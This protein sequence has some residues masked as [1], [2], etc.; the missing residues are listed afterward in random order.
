P[1]P[2]GVRS[3]YAP[4]LVAFVGG[5]GWAAGVGGPVGWFPLGPGEIYNPWYHASRRYYSNLNLGGLRGYRGHDRSTIARS[6][7]NHYN[8]YRNGSPPRGEHYA[9]RDAPRGFTAIPG[10]SFAGGQH[11]QRDLLHIDRHQLAT[12]SVLPRGT[13]LR[14]AAGSLAPVRGAHARALP[15]NGFNREVVARHAPPVQSS[16]RR[17]D[18]TTRVAGAQ[19]ASTYGASVRVLNAAGPAD[20]AGS[21]RVGNPRGAAGNSRWPFGTPGSPSRNLPPT[22]NVAAGTPTDMQNRDP[23][24]LRQGELPSARFAHPPSDRNAAGQREPMPRSGVSY[25]SNAGDN[26]PRTIYR[27]PQTLPQVPQIQRATPI[28]SPLPSNDGRSPRYETARSTPNDVPPVRDDTRTPRF[29][30]AGNAPRADVR[31]QPRAMPEPVRQDYQP[32]YQQ[33]PRAAP[34]YVQQPPRAEMV[35]PQREAAPRP[36]A[37]PRERAAN[38]NEQQH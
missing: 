22:S 35:R 5:G 12:S 21:N 9:N 4:A 3:I 20:Q 17:F 23:V 19:R 24:R 32:R 26:Q 10:R 11:V 15:T 6:I 31:E 30:R 1:G 25:I 36:A 7:D 2:R 28:N 37:A 13:N 14:P 18:P 38:K 29:E 27:G 34:Q 8:S 16:G 33:Q